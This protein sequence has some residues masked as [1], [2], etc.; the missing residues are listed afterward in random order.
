MILLLLLGIALLVCDELAIWFFFWL[1]SGQ[2]RHW[3]CIREQGCMH[4]L[5]HRRQGIGPGTALGSRSS[6]ST[7]RE[8]RYFLGY[9]TNKESNTA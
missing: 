7:S 6:N 4:S 9:V 1:V 3:G 5:A 8:H 2:R